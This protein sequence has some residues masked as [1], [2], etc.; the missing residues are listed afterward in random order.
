MVANFLEAVQAIL[1]EPHERTAN[2]PTE[3]NTHVGAGSTAPS[4]S[5][6]SDNDDDDSCE[7]TCGAGIVDLFG[8]VE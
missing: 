7:F 8:L 4:P 5:P 3:V 1:G 2:F 6:P